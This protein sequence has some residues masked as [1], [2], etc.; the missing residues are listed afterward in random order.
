MHER[1]NENIVWFCYWFTHN[2]IVKIYF[3]KTIVFVSISFC[4]QE[5][6]I[7]GSTDV[8]P[9]ISCKQNIVSSGQINIYGKKINFV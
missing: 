4:S 8:A 6:Q 2:C 3:W 5:A 1:L 9:Y 7:D